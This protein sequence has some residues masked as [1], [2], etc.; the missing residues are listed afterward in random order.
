MSPTDPQRCMYC[1][2][3]AVSSLT[4][5]Q[6]RKYM[7]VCPQH[8]TLARAEI[9]KAG[10]GVDDRVMIVNPRGPYE[11]LRWWSLQRRALSGGDL[12]EQEMGQRVD[13]QRRQSLQE[14]PPAEPLLRRTD[15]DYVRK[16][17][18]RATGNPVLRRTDPDYVDKAVQR[19]RDLI[20]KFEPQTFLQRL[21][22]DWTTLRARKI[23]DRVDVLIDGERYTLYT[24]RG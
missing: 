24:K 7:P 16:A 19:T 9:R 10:S 14:A 18:T 4:Y 3:A 12:T 5:D 23:S 8:E 20:R 2:E 13:P 21:G 1:S 6:D 15:P 11:S 17:M 22:D